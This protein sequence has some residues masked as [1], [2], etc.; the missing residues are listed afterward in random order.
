VH[1]VNSD[2][3]DNRWVNLKEVTPRENNAMKVQRE[4]SNIREMGALYQVSG[5]TTVSTLEQA[6]ALRDGWQK[7][8]AQVTSS[9]ATEER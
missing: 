4:D 3:E 5:C 1:H 8:V 9:D 6:R 2:R 7:L